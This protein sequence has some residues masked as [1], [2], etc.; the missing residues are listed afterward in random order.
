MRETH[1]KTPA[2]LVHDEGP[3]ELKASLIKKSVDAAKEKKDTT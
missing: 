3:D 1:C 2:V